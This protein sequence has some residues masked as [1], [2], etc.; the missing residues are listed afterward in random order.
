MVIRTSQIN[1]YGHEI[2]GKLIDEAVADDQS[3]I[4]LL[5][6]PA[7][8]AGTIMDHAD[9]V[10]DCMGYVPSELSN[11]YTKVPDTMVKE[12]LIIVDKPKEE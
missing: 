5:D 12:T 11:K 6:K 8:A 9:I 10:I 2:I 3:I 4:V 7:P 1:D